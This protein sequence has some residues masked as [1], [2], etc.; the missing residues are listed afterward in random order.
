MAPSIFGSS[1]NREISGVS[2]FEIRSVSRLPPF[3]KTKQAIV[4][5]NAPIRLNENP[6]ILRG[7]EIEASGTMLR[8]SLV[9]DLCRPL[10]VRSV[11]LRLT[12]EKEVG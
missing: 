3:K 10:S 9:L 12:G 5:I 2:L 7:H 6:L 11:R 4:L 8:G 1:T